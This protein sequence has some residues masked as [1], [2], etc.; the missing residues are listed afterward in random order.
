[1]EKP[2]SDK[3]KIKV[4]KIGTSKS[5]G[6]EA[7]KDE[8]KKEP[9]GN[10][11]E[12]PLEELQK[13]AISLGMPKEDAEKFESEGLL[14]ATINTLKAVKADTKVSLEEKPN[15]KEE[16]DTERH[17]QS[18]ADRQK[19][20]F[21]SLPKVRILIP[22]EGEEKPGQIE[23]VL[24]DR[25]NKVLKIS[26]AVWSKTFNGYKVIVPKGVYTEISEAVA[27]NIAEEF[28]QVQKSNARFSIDRI[29]P[30]TNRPVAEQL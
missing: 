14:Q 7:P 2:K 21:D 30:K 26:G 9:E 6:V 8:L 4:E 1:M 18:K 20:Y 11:P 19:A 25:G 29:D 15:P 17:W 13:E 5:G 28:N 22:C 12:S 24:D 3:P 16:R 27:D 10:R 23:E